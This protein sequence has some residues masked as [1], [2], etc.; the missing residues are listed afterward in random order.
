MVAVAGLPITV[1]AGQPKPASAPARQR[2]NQGEAQMNTITANDGIR[3]FYKDWGTGPKVV[4]SHGWP[5]NAGACDPHMLFLGQNG[6]RL[7]AHASRGHGRSCQRWHG[8]NMH[9]YAD[10]LGGLL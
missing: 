10:D 5:L 3:I 4:V 1:F 9:T 2:T 7:I 6:Y 8:N